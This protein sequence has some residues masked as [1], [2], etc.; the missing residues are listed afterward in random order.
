MWIQ[1]TQWVTGG[2]SSTYA[3]RGGDDEAGME[4]GQPTINGLRVGMPE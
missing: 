1:G 3:H 4:A 2:L